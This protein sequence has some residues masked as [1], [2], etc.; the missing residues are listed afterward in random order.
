MRFMFPLVTLT[1]ELLARFT[2]ID[3]DREM[4]LIATT[5][6]RDM[7]QIVAVARYVTLADAR[8]CEFA[9]VVADQWQGRGVATILLTRLIAYARSV[10]VGRM[11]GSVLAHNERMLSLLR[12]LGFTIHA[13]PSEAGVMQVSITLSEDAARGE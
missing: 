8:V 9:V 13:Q 1:P 7:E 11:E 3:Y 4:A 5:V 6:E 12:T 2:Q 10:G